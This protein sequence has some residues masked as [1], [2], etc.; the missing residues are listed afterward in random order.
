MKAGMGMKLPHLKRLCP[1]AKIVNTFHS[2]T[3]QGGKD[4]AIF[5][6]RFDFQ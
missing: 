5:F 1:E 2:G 4:Q 6:M 3:Q